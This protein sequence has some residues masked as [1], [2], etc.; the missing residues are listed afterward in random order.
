MRDQQFKVSVPTRTYVQDQT[1]AHQLAI[2]IIFY[3]P[4][5]FVFWY[6]LP[7]DYQSEPEVDLFGRLPTTW[8][9]IAVLHD[10]IGDAVAVAR[11]H[12]DDWYVGA[13]TDEAARS[14][15]IELSFLDE[16][17]TY[18]ATIYSDLTATS[19]QVETKEVNRYSVLTASMISSGG[20]AIWL[21]PKAVESE[22]T[23]AD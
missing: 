15:P 17:K 3:S 11:R 2:S 18:S 6:D 8:D 22:T 23:H 14:L 21:T 7:S 9:E 13:I 5:K 20:Q 12:G 4:L 1:R 16:S 19:V 10:V